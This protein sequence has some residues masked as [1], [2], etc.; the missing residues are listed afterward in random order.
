MIG[1]NDRRVVRVAFVEFVLQRVQ[2]A[3]GDVG[4]DLWH[5]RVGLVDQIHLY[6]RQDNDLIPRHKHGA[7][8]G[9]EG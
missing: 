3:V 5:F 8:Q 1:T 6:R 9:T 7:R 2:E 4:A